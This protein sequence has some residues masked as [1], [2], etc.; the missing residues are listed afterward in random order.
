MPTS[1]GLETHSLGI[2][3]TN[4][5]GLAGEHF[6]LSFNFSNSFKFTRVGLLS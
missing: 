6:T 4:A 5:K 3:T 1:S 2:N